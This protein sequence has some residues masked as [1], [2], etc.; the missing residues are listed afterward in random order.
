MNAT[1]AAQVYAR[2]KA[3]GTIRAAQQQRVRQRYGLVYGLTAGL[4]F[5]LVAWAWDA[6]R[7]ATLHVY[8]SWLKLLVGAPLCVAVGT[9][10]GWLSIRLDRAPVTL[11]LWILVGGVFARL[12]AWLPFQGYEWLVTRV[13]PALRTL[14]SYPYTQTVQTRVVFWG[15]VVLGVIVLAS[16]LL[17]YLVENSLSASNTF[18]RVWPLLVWGSFF[19]LAGLV[20]EANLTAPLRVPLAAVDEA[21]QTTVATGEAGARALRPVMA[22]VSPGYRQLLTGYDEEIFIVNVGINFDDTWVS[23]VVIGD[24]VSNC[25][26]LEAE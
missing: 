15:A 16:L 2:N 7:L 12:A 3:E 5:V 6:T 10:A 20:A 13:N 21:L 17:H 8:G 25:Q 14:I 18:E 9:V 11:L 22:L 19:L 26:S 23:C 24:S 1:R 4:V